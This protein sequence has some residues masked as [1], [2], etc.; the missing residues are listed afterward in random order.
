MRAVFVPQMQCLHVT[1]LCQ[2]EL[3]QVLVHVS[4]IAE[5]CSATETHNTHIHTTPEVTTLGMRTT[6]KQTATQRYTHTHTHT[7]T[8]I[9]IHIHTHTHT[10]THTH[11]HTHTHTHT[12]TQV[13]Q[14]LGRVPSQTTDQCNRALKELQRQLQ[15]STVKQN[16]KIMHQT[17]HKHTHTKMIR[18]GTY[19]VGV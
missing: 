13:Q 8:H 11:S 9:H 19:S 4:H 5:R 17:A 3:A 2:I 16:E 14:R 6:G 15:L 18:Q 7:H 10:H 1:F 12:H